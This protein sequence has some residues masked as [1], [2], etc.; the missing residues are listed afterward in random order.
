MT[1]ATESQVAEHAK[2]IST[3]ESSLANLADSVRHGFENIH[4]ELSTLKDRP[5]N[6]GWVVAGISLTI[7][8]GALTLTPVYNLAIVTGKQLG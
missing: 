4:N 1:V 6:W 7:T 3:L 8:I 2:A 5:T